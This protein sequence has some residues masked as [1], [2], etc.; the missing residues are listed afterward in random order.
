[1]Q[2]TTGLS[3][4]QVGRARCRVIVH[5]ASGRMGA[6]LCTLVSDDDALELIGAVDTSES[7]A[8]GTHSVPGDESS[9]IVQNADGIDVLADVV[10][11]FSTAEAVASAI[12]C[13]RRADAA[14][15]V[16]TTA[17]SA[18]TRDDLHAETA[19]RAVLIAPNTALGRKCYGPNSFRCIQIARIGVRMQH[20]GGASRR[21]ARCTIRHGNSPSGRH[22]QR[23]CA[24]R[25]R[26]F[27]SRR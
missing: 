26:P 1:M 8:I 23:W 4:Q 17:L 7:R 22:Q 3:S 25:R 24:C 6:R 9:P 27:H 15:L 14:L 19:R 18:Q 5:G 10:I 21:E 12:E 13:A 11:D 2:S 20:R 16:G